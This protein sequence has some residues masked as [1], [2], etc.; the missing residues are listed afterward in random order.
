MIMIL[1]NILPC[2]DFSFARL[3]KPQF[4]VMAGNICKTEKHP[5]T[6]QYPLLDS[7]L[8][9]NRNTQNKPKSEMCTH[10]TRSKYTRIHLWDLWQSNNPPPNTSLHCISHTK[11]LSLEEQPLLADLSLLSESPSTR[12]M[13]RK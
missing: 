3:S 10:E 8:K 9:A 7:S 2:F 12:G 4:L 11:T 6:K 5:K 13:E 1:F